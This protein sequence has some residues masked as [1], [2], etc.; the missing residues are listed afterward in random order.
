MWVAACRVTQ[1]GS[2][3]ITANELAA[4]FETLGQKPAKS[5]L[6]SML[7]EIDT[8][9]NGTIASLLS[10]EPRITSAIVRPLYVLM[11]SVVPRLG[12]RI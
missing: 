3:S 4:V 1:D 12:R 10:I 7:K 11:Y 8:D 5:E 6:D 2:G 9:G